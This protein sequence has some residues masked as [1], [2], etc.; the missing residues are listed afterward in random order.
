M[1]IKVHITPDYRIV[2]MPD[3]TFEISFT[4]QAVNGHNYDL[5][6]N[7]PDLTWSNISTAIHTAVVAYGATI[8]ITINTGETAIYQPTTL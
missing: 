2:K 5:S 4:A 1:A 7:S 6:C 3:N 8:G